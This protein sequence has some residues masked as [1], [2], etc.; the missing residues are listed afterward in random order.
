MPAV[1][2]ETRYARIGPDRIAFQTVG[3]GPDLVLAG[4]FGHVDLFWEDPRMSLFLRGLASFS[5]L[6]RFDRRGTGASD[7]MPDD[8]LPP[9][10]SY[11]D[12]LVAVLDAVGSERAA[13]AALGP[14]AGPMAVF[15]AGSRPGRT[16]ALVLA[17]A[18]ARY[19]AADDYP[20]GLPRVR[21]EAIV[22][23]AAE[24][25]GTE[26]LAAANSPGHADDERFLRWSARL[27][28]SMASPRTA[29]AYLRSLL[30]LDVRPLLPLLD[31]PTLVL[32]QSGHPFVPVEHGRYLAEHIPRAKLVE[33]EG[34]DVAVVWDQPEVI[35][36][37]IEAFLTGADR[38][39]PSSRVLATV[40]FTDI[41]AS[42]EQ[43]GRRGD[44]RWRDLLDVHDE[45]ARRLVQAGGGRFV[46]TTGDGVL[47]TFD[48]PG[49]AIRFTVALRQ[50]LELIGLRIRAGLHTGEVELRDEDVGGL[51]VHIAARVM[52]AAGPGEILTSRTVRDLVVGSDISLAD[53]GM[54]QLK[55]VEE[56]WPLFAVTQA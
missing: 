48:G 50:E 15:F 21:G 7:P 1:Q 29:A 18:T 28:R 11:A 26:D 5:R 31:V 51:A 46:K 23:R 43:A 3:E 35:L 6:I 32:A 13:I 36:A 30:E 27:Q 47:A 40:V 25:W 53:R 37:E 38:P 24:Q 22:D 2:P 4:I 33:I 34:D 19:L 41:V 56:P 10:E 42:T 14:Q 17:D 55:G 54:H 44:R 8:S 9:W 39:A 45:V 16:R 20:I 12:E 49:R 52:A